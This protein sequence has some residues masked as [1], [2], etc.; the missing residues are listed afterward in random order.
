MRSPPEPA[1][2]LMI[3]TFGPQR[4]AIGCVKGRLSPTL[5]LK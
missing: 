5:E 2:S 1:R 3:I 4:P